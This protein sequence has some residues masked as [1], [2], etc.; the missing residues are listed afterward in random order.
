MDRGMPKSRRND[1]YMQVLLFHNTNNMKKD[2]KKLINKTPVDIL[3]LG[4]LPRNWE[5]I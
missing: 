4:I 2:I 5:D 1:G 3:L